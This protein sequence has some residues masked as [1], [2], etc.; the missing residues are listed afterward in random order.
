M[1]D[2]IMPEP[3][4]EIIPA[5]EPDEQELG[6]MVGHPA[7][8]IRIAS[9]IRELLQEVRQSALDASS[10]ER[11]RK[12]YDQTLAELREVLSEDLQRELDALA[13]PLDKTPSESEI[14]VAQAQLVGWLEGLLHGIQATLVAQHMQAQAQLQEMRRRAL[15]SGLLGRPEKEREGRPGQ[16]L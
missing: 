8:I 14:R 3:N 10:R 16:Y 9:M 12:I 4:H 11:L 7:K 15:P 6:P 1:E 13:I 5:R 2:T